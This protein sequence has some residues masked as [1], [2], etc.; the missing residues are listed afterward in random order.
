MQPSATSQINFKD[1]CFVKTC[2]LHESLRK[3]CVSIVPAVEFHVNPQFCSIREQISALV[4]AAG[5]VVNS[6]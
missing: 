5:H 1:S 4:I 3:C 6:E 2:H